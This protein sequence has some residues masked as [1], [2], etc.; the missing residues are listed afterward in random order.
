MGFKRIE[1]HDLTFWSH[2][3]IGHVTTRF[4]IGISYLWSLEPN[5]KS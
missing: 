3:V 5:L 2:V 4:P 1:G